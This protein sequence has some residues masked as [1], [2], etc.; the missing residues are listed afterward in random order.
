MCDLISKLRDS[1]M[2][3]LEF[4]KTK[5]KQ[6]NNNTFKKSTDEKKLCDLMF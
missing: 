3:D 1:P 6:T 4:K 5:I 2:L